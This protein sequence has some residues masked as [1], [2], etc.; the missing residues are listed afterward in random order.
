MLS[1]R[2]ANNRNSLNGIVA[3]KDVSQTVSVRVS[4]K[5]VKKMRSATL[6]HVTTNTKKKPLCHFRCHSSVSSSQAEDCNIK[7]ITPLR[8]CEKMPN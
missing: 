7:Y 5:E 8:A 3:Y 6:S 4:V 1:I 2:R